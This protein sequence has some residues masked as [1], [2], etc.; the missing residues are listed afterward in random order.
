MQSWIKCPLYI[1]DLHSLKDYPSYKYIFLVFQ[2][3]E[4]LEKFPTVLIVALKFLGTCF[5]RVIISFLFFF[6]VRLMFVDA[7]IEEERIIK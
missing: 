4:E 3:T 2:R 7:Q 6:S 5:W 1:T